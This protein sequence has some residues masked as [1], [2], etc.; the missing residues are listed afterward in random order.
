M[1]VALSDAGV[2]TKRDRQKKLGTFLSSAAVRRQIA[3]K[4]CLRIEVFSTIFAPPDFF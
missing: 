1:S 2:H 4:L 3:T